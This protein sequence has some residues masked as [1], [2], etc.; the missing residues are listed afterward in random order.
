MKKSFFSGFFG[1]SVALLFA[2]CN[3]DDVNIIDSKQEADVMFGID[4]TDVMSKAT[5]DPGECLSLDQL[6]NLAEYDK[7]V[8]DFIITKAQADGS[9]SDVPYTENINVVGDKLIAD[10]IPLPSGDSK[11][12]QF[13]VRER[14]ENG[15]LSA[16]LFSAV[17]QGADKYLLAAVSEDELLPITVNV[18]G[19]DLATKKTIELAVV[20]TE[21]RS[22][23]EFGF[24]MWD[25]KFVHFH[26]LSFMVDDFTEEVGPFV[27]SGTLYI[28]KAN[29]AAND[30]SQLISPA[31]ENIEFGK[32]ISSME[33][34]PKLWFADDMSIDNDKEFFGYRFV[35]DGGK[36]FAGS[37]SLEEL[38]NYEHSNAWMQEYKCLDFDIHKG[39]TWFLEDI[40]MP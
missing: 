37:A 33:D 21:K 24:K 30:D 14:Y 5:V 27:E 38:F 13:T 25:I 40:T 19:E 2:S 7:L 18:G 22:A 26:S 31:L 35:T 15:S 34:L 10:P 17:S 29:S 3:S 28:H 11:L 23:I 1:V 6:K 12:I 4:I 8:A 16:P 32:Q 9:S 39:N 20:C 36:T